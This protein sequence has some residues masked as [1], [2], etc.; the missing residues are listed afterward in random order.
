MQCRFEDHL[1]GRALVM[2]GEPLR[3]SASHAGELETV[4]SQLDQA[5][6]AGKWIALALDYELGEWL[7]PEISAQRRPNTA[8]G[9]P[10]ASTAKPAVPSSSSQARPLNRATA[11][12]RLRAWVFDSAHHESPWQTDPGRAAGITSITPR[13]PRADYLK[14]IESIRASIGAGEVYQVNYTMPLDISYEGHSET[15]YRRLASRHPCAHGAYIED[16]DLRVMSFS[17]ELFVA[18]TGDTLTCR[19]MKGT[20][21]RHPDALTDQALGQELRASAKNLA[22]NLMIVDLLRNDL[23]RLA[24][25]G[26]VQVDPLFEL[27]RYPSVWTLT[28]TIRARAPHLPLVALLHALFPC[29]S[30][31]GAPKI[32]AMQHI[33][34]LEPWPRGLYCGSLGWIAPGGDL[35]LNVA[36]RT[37]VSTAPGKAAYHV[38]GGIVYDSDA[39]MEWEECLWKARLL[40]DA[41]RDTDALSRWSARPTATPATESGPRHAATDRDTAHGT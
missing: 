23:G 31:T 26:T 37:L 20:A 30:I 13:Q 41:C 40:L 6:A 8:M 22:E 14:R 32:A 19:P 12:P 28:S 35:S 36:I 7:E 10:A 15:L 11:S 27:E 17:P 18:R 2:E 24:N 16:G 34:A 3:V 9:L 4:L 5:S 39:A 38:G 25:T 1:A 33:Q 21:P 29:G